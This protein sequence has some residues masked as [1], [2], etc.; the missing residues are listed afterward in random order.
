VA[1]LHVVEDLPA[2]VAG[3]LV[4]LGRTAPEGLIRWDRFAQCGWVEVEGDG[5]CLRLEL[6]S[7]GW[8]ASETCEEIDTE[9]GTI[10]G[11]PV[12][13]YVE[14]TTGDGRVRSMRVLGRLLGWA[15]GLQAATD[16]TG[17]PIGYLRRRTE[18][19]VNTLDTPDARERAEDE[20][21]AAYGAAQDRRDAFRVEEG[22]GDDE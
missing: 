15:Q 5:V 18:T 6:H 22:G 20:A 8:W 10:T 7:D 17:D 14:C 1:D 19:G 3:M 16:A 12:G 13:G 11:S 9:H 4:L 21:Q 2:D